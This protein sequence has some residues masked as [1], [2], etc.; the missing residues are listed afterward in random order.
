[1]LDDSRPAFRPVRFTVALLLAGCAGAVAPE[2]DPLPLSVPALVLPDVE[3]EADE[4]EGVRDAAPA[5]H[6]PSVRPHRGS[7][8][9]VL[10]GSERAPD[11][12]LPTPGS[13]LSLQGTDPFHSRKRTANQF[14][15]SAQVSMVVQPAVPVSLRKPSGVYL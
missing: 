2:A 8:L 9:G 1:M 10:R 3:A 6:D 14:R 5:R 4:D 7:S 12:P 15:A 11:P 13:G